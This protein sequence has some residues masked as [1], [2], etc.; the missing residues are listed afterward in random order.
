MK[1]KKK[2]FNGNI[3]N[4]FFPMFGSMCKSVSLRNIPMRKILQKNIV[5]FDVDGYFMLLIGCILSK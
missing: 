3:D 4:A 1:Q 5:Q 2:L